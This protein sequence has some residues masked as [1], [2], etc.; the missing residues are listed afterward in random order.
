MKVKLL[1]VACLTIGAPQVAFADD[2]GANADT[3]AKGVCQFYDH[4]SL[5]YGS[6]QECYN[7]EF[8]KYLEWYPQDNGGSD[9]SPGY[10]PP[11]VPVIPCT[12]RLD[13]PSN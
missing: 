13:C 10:N 6:Y 11:P 9:P 1:L 3:Y 4:P 5:G 7:A 12:G 2:A 8:A